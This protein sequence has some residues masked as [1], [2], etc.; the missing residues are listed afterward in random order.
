VSA[1][2]DLDATAVALLATLCLAVLAIAVLATLVL[3]RRKLQRDIR[4]LVASLEGMRGGRGRSRPDVPEDSPLGSLA[5]S[6]HRLGQDLTARWH[7]SARTSMQL[8]ALRSAAPDTAVVATD[9]EG[10]IRSFNEH[11]ESLFGWGE[12]DVVGRPAAMLFPEES[13]RDLLPK[14][15]RRDVRSRGLRDRATLLRRDGT[16]FVAELALRVLHRDGGEGTAGFLVALQDVD[17]RVVLERRLARAEE[18]QRHVF[19]RLAEPAIVVAG[20]TVVRANPAACALFDR[21]TDELDRRSLLELVATRDVLRVREWLASGADG[22]LFA[23]LDAGG[24]ELRVG[25]RAAPV[26]HEGRQALL[27]LLADRTA[28]ERLAAELR[29]NENRLDAVIEASSDGILV[30]ADAP[31][32]AGAVVHVINRAFLD[33]FGLRQD[34]VLGAGE[35][36]LLRLLRER[37]DGAEQIAALLAASAR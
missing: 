9:E 22:D 18:R 19:E 12:P 10:T 24:G 5:D 7:E 3:T 25:L 23:A 1:V 11:A 34:Q 28:E 21:G 36:T 35:S 14:L 8:E 32:P 26:D 2:A 4:E 33:L 27:V 17:D 37:G 15:L 6:V 16:T 29:R 31:P 13:W 20:D 30:L